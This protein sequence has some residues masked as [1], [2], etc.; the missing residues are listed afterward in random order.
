MRKGPRH[1]HAV[2]AFVQWMDNKKG[3]IEANMRELEPTCRGL[4]ILPYYSLNV[5]TDS[6]PIL[7]VEQTA[8]DRDWES[9]D[10]GS[11][12]MYK[13]RF[14]STI[15]GLV[16]GYRDEV[17]DDLAVELE[18]S[19]AEVLNHRHET[20]KYEGW[21]FYFNETMPMPASTFGVTRMGQNL[22]RGFT[23]TIIIDT[24]LSAP[25]APG[26]ST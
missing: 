17:M 2:R 11:G 14:S 16:A 13:T 12:P 24:L 5:D 25:Q 7:M 9:L 6:Y 4:T 8:V 3:D 21:Q 22:A 26:T 10:V 19:V 23:A 15:W 20:F 1:Y 18:A